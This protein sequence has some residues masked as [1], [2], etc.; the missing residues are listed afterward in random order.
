[1]DD[2]RFDALSRRLAGV[3][4]RRGAVRASLV[5]AG[6]VLARVVGDDARAGN[7]DRCVTIRKACGGGKSCCAGTVCAVNG[8]Y[9]SE[10]R[11]CRNRN[12]SCTVACDCCKVEDYC[13]NG[14]C[15]PDYGFLRTLQFPWCADEQEP[16]RV[17]GDWD[18]H[19]A[20]QGFALD[21]TRPFDTSITGFPGGSAGVK[22]TTVVAPMAGPVKQFRNSGSSYGNYV[23]IG[24]NHGWTVILAHLDSIAPTLK[25]PVAIGDVI[26]IVGATGLNNP[27]EYHIHF[28]LRLNNAKPPRLFSTTENLELFAGGYRRDDFRDNNGRTFTSTQICQCRELREGCSSGNQCCNAPRAICAQDDC[29]D[30]NVCC[31]PT[32]EPCVSGRD[33]DCCDDDLCEDFVCRNPSSLRAATATRSDK[34]ESMEDGAASTRNAAS[35]IHRQRHRHPIVKHTTTDQNRRKEGVAS[36]EGSAR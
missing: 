19:D 13:I 14:K 6:G 2:R 36:D 25:S 35:D 22:Y 1:M 21:F 8:C 7:N 24:P 26:G 30:N 3:A 18:G 29:H 28:E 4:T 11:C 10:K 12:A 34:R 27:A 9:G 16:R 20:Q 17:S 32:G 5:S 31:M 33:C 23:A 15:Q